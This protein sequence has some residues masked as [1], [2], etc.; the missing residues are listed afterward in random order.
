MTSFQNRSV[1]ASLVAISGLLVAI[2]FGLAIGGAAD[3][4]Q[5]S[6]PGVLVRY[7]T[8][9]TKGLMNLAMAIAIGSL[10]LA[11]F[12][13]NDKSAVLRKLLNLSAVFAAAWFLVG[14][15]HF[16]FSFMSVSGASFSLEASFSRGLLVYATEIELG[17]SLGLNLVAALAIAT[18]ALMVGSLTGTALTAAIGLASLIPL[19]LIGHASGTEN[20]SLAVNS[21][22]M[23]LV[24]IVVWVGGLIALFAIRPELQGNSK[25]MALRYSSLALAS[26]ALVAISGIGSSYVRLPSFESIASPYGLLLLLKIVLLIGLG[27]FGAIYRRGILAKI[28]QK[29]S[30][31]KLALLEI[32]VMGLALGTGTALARTAP[33]LEQGEF[34]IPTPAQFLTGEKLPPE[35]TFETFLTVTKLDILWLVI[36]LA[37]MGAY[38]LGVR[39]LR[40]RGDSWPIARTASWLLG[41]LLLIFTTSG[42][43]NAYQE[44]LF[45]VHMIAHMSL[46]MAIPV[47]LVPGAPVTLLM[48]AVQKRPDQSRGVREWVLW[49]VHTKPAMF[50]AHP[51]FAAVNFAASLV[52]FYFTP[53]FDW[54]TREHIGHQWM[55]IHFLITGYLFVQSLIG[56]DPGPTRVGYPFRIVTLIAVMAFHAFFGIALMTGSGLLLPDWFGAMGRTWGV[57]PLEDQQN[58]G[59]IAWAI[60]ELPTIALAII[61][62]W[63]WF[64]S[65]RRDSARLDRAS[66]RSGNKD[67]DSYNQML[68]R[69]NQR[70]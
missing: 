24:G 11:A 23:H 12:A 35:L 9:I 57:S 51:A 17:V 6:D 56:I 32:S 52:V 2:M 27:V 25:P 38:L 37:A 54:A 33:P 46:T 48:R 42:S 4:L 69:I 58:G 45:S 10:V 63:Q 28:D 64:K 50:I 30:F 26:F 31:F 36:A 44:Y 62:S 47:L 13:A 3:P 41:M 66:D 49:A 18:L 39:V 67:L 8:P 1:A 15:A 59:A 60:G 34:M 61:V 20:H 16:L 43:L 68:D 19:A 5:F 14:S 21:L 29:G 7:G 55:I 53:I 70:P 65:D 22:G 40:K